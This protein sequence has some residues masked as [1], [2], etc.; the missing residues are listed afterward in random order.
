[1]AKS[2]SRFFPIAGSPLLLHNETVNQ[3]NPG[4]V[5]FCAGRKLTA[6]LS[7]PASKFPRVVLTQFDTV[8]NGGSYLSR[9][10][11]RLHFGLG[12]CNKIDRVTIK[13]PR[14]G[15]QVVSDVGYQCL[16]LHRGDSEIKA[17]HSLLRSPAR[18]LYTG[19]FA[20][21][22]FV[23]ITSAVAFIFN[24]LHPYCKEILNREH[25][26]WRRAFRLR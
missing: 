1:M 3:N 17:T 15:T 5:C 26:L 24:M 7:A 10:D 21:E 8:R 12:T 20:A 14:S 11:P 18:P 25:G 23:D 6:M 19:T 16:P 22:D 13:W 2:T 9:N 4:L